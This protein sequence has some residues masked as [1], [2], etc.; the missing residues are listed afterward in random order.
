MG[1]EGIPE[2]VTC[3]LRLEKDTEGEEF[4]A[5]RTGFFGLHVCPSS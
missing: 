3:E 1:V 2:E 5:K 4:Q